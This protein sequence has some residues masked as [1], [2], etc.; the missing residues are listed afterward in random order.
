MAGGAA[1]NL[2]AEQPAGRETGIGEDVFQRADGGKARSHFPRTHRGEA[3]PE[4]GGHHFAGGA[5]AETPA[6]QDEGEIRP[7]SAASIHATFLAPNAGREKLFLGDGFS[8]KMPRL[9][10]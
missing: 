3:K 2:V 10:C 9:R 7:Q 6:F 1:A 4:P 8:T 5:V